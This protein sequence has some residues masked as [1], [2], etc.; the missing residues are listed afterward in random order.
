MTSPYFMKFAYIIKNKYM[1]S[2]LR[3]FDPVKNYYIFQPVEYPERPLLV[4]IETLEP[5]EN[6]HTYQTQ[7]S[8]PAKP[9]KIFIEYIGS[10][11]PTDQ[12]LELQKAVKATIPHII[13]NLLHNAIAY[14]CHKVKNSSKSSKIS[15]IWL[16]IRNKQSRFKK[17]FVRWSVYSKLFHL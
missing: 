11:R 15:K 17:L 5:A 4:P 10:R 12:E 14:F 6:Y 16:T 13:P 9:V 3:N 7:W 2:T 8:A 1:K